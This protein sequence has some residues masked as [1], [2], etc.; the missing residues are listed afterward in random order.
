M[1]LTVLVPGLRNPKHKL[2][3]FLQ[4]LIAGLKELWDVGILAYDISTKQ[5]FQLRA[6][7][8]WTI[9]DFPDYAMLSGWSTAGLLACPYCIG[10]SKAF[11]LSKSG[12]QSWFD[13]HH[14]FLPTDHIF[15]RNGYAFR[16]NMV[17]IAT[18]PPILSGNEILHLITNLGLK[19]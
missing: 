19:K 2:D 9:S 18:T 5:N 7:L 1:F 8:M 14:K 13:T 4:P 12:K 11:R 3:D 15:S 16:K 6:A 10:H 17:V